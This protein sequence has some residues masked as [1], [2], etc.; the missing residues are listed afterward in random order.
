MDLLYLSPQLVI[1]VGLTIVPF[2]VALPIIFTDTISLLDV[3]VRFVGL[4]NF[5][6]IF[7]PPIVRDFLPALARTSAFVMLNYCMVF[8]FGIPLA[9]LMFEFQQSRFKRPF[10]VVIYLPMMMSGVG[11]GLMMGM[12]FSRD[13][14]SI[15]LLLLKLGWIEEAL[16][17]KNP[18]TTVSTLALLVGWRY[19]GFNMAIFLSGLLAIPQSTIEAAIVDGCRYHQRIWYVYLPQIRGSILIATIFCLIG[20]FGVVD[21]PIGMGGLYANESAEFLSIILLQYGFRSM[22]GT[23][24]TGGTLAQAITMALTVYV[25]LFF[26]AYGLTRLQR[27]MQD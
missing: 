25:P 20:S 7:Q 3:D 13:S 4:R 1:Y 24:S 2:L 11:I 6:D 17:I 15:N 27:K 23:E 19:A 18:R 14:G 10:F 16:D 22:A 8:I 5:V 21:E 12:L 26:C 9:L